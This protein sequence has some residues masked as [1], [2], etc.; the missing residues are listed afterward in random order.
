MEGSVRTGSESAQR[1]RAARVR[2]ARRA[3]KPG[4]SKYAMANIETIDIK[5]EP[6]KA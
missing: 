6:K 5:V 4:A 3:D 1:M 2:R